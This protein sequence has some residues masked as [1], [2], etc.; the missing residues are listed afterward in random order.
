M[1]D[2]DICVQGGAATIVAPV[3]CPMAEEIVH[4]C[5]RMVW[6]RCRRRPGEAKWVD[7]EGGSKGCAR[8]KV[9]TRG[10]EQGRSTTETVRRGNTC[11]RAVHKGCNA[12]MYRCVAMS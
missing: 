7:Q 9:R 4:V 2:E 3:A 1:E 5:A 11:G 8:N 12:N 10:G 6:G